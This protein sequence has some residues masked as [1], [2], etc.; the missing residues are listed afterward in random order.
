MLA[1]VPGYP[2]SV[3]VET[4]TE[5]PVRVRNH[6]GTR[7]DVFWWGC[8][9]DRIYTS[10][11]VAGLYPDRGYILWFLQISLQSCEVEMPGFWV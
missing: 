5:T 10:G 7:P 2:A 9:P 8:Y 1:R 11:F 6:Q 4:G 3:W